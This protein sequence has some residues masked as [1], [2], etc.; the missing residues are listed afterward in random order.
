[1][2]PYHLSRGASLSHPS[3][4][5]QL[6]PS[7]ASYSATSASR[8][9][10]QMATAAV[11]ST[12]STTGVGLGAGVAIG[13]RL[14]NGVAFGVAVASAGADVAAGVGA[15][16]GIGV[17]ANVGTVGGTGVGAGVGSG[18]AGSALGVAVMSNGSGRG[19]QLPR[20]TAVTSS[21]ARVDTA[22]NRRSGGWC[23]GA[24]STRIASSPCRGVGTTGRSCARTRPRENSTDGDPPSNWL[25]GSLRSPG[26]PHSSLPRIRERRLLPLPPLPTST[27]T[28]KSRPFYEPN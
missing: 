14:A 9:D 17:G 16:V 20:A 27:T 11:G 22:R 19:P 1:M 6:A 8:F 28:C 13:T 2:T 3:F 15:A 18:V 5:V 23:C 4:C 10:M 25:S 12:T 7:V 21:S 24:D 26:A